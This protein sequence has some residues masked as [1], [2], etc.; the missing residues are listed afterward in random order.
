MW[1]SEGKNGLK[2]LFRFSGIMKKHTINESSLF[3]KILE[4]FVYGVY[5]RPLCET[6]YYIWCF[7]KLEYE[8]HTM[9]SLNKFK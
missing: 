7:A 4:N 8:S 2:Y 6:L 1:T 3:C 5:V 9:S